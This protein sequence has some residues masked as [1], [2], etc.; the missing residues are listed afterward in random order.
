ML[1]S[2]RRRNWSG[3][4]QMPLL[5]AHQGTSLPSSSSQRGSFAEW[6]QLPTDILLYIFS[7]LSRAERRSVMF[8]CRLWNSA[9]N[10]YTLWKNSC[11]RLKHLQV[12]MTYW[13]LIKFRG[14]TN[15]CL[16]SI[17]MASTIS[18]L[19]K[20]YDCSGGLV[21][22][23][24]AIKEAVDDH[25][26]SKMILPPVAKFG[27]LQILSVEGVRE[28]GV[29]SYAYKL[30]LNSGMLLAA[31]PTLKELRLVVVSVTGN[32]EH[33]YPPQHQQLESLTL[34]R[35]A[36][37]DRNENVICVM[38][39]H[40]PKLKHLEILYP[41]K[42]VRSIHT[43]HGF[44]IATFNQMEIEGEVL[45]HLLKL[46]INKCNLHGSLWKPPVPTRMK[47]IQHLDISYCVEIPYQIL[48]HLP[49]LKEL[50]LSG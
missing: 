29:F 31:L 38:T 34:D 18:A 10:D 27:S 21:S 25:V 26:F 9:M 43:Y 7:Y 2:C 8:V 32:C 44:E 45:T 6:S 11:V 20:L 15:V 39:S 24:L 12:P 16:Q 50:N 46:K 30:S 42:P 47:Y 23:Q 5:S 40:L 33:K 35:C 3:T 48:S 22:L 37:D 28:E 49:H 14:I 17:S 1:A 19:G 13:S 36:M 41:Y 4:S